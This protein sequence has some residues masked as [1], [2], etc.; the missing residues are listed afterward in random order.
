[1]YSLA[2][3]N[4]VFFIEIYRCSVMRLLYSVQKLSGFLF[5]EAIKPAQISRKVDLLARSSLMQGSSWLIDS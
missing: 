4:L 3:F 2:W 5:S 1:M